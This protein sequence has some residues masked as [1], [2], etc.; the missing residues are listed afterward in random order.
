MIE[1]IVCDGN[2]AAAWGVSKAKPDMVAVYPITPQSSLAEYVAQFV[3]DGVIE[4]DLMDVEGE[5]S[6]LSVLQGACLAGARTYTATCGQGLAFMF[7]PYFRTPPLRLPI[8]MS[9]VTRDG[10]T[11]QCVWGGQQDAMT[12]KEVGWIQMYCETNQE[13]LDTIIMAYRVAEDR[14]VM[15]PVNVCHDGNY[16][17]YGVEQVLLPDQEMVNGFLGEKNTNWHVALDPDKPMG[18]DPLT[19]GAGGVGPSRFVRYR[20]GTCNGMQNA[21]DVISAAHDEWAALTGR[22]YAPLVEEYLLDDADYAIITIGGMTGAGKDAV[23]EMRLAGENV[24]LIKI[25]TFRPFPQ[26][27]LLDAVSKVGAV[28][29]IDRA[30]NFG[31]GCGPVYQEVLGVLYRMEKKIPAVSFI[32]GLAGADITINDFKNVITTTKRALNGDPPKSTIWINE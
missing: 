30:V 23:D 12:V 25:K 21:L 13:I 11:P 2:E 14:N 24:G 22:Q 3:A 5:H 18:V 27:A 9:L 8:V 1:K 16:Q 17:S 7:E 20:K 32:G 31:W 28:G 26:A 15:L 19:G 29:V 4:A 10:I 6:V